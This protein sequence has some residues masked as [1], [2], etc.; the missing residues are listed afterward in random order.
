VTKNVSFRDN[1]VTIDVSH[2]IT[3]FLNANSIS[4]GGQKKFLAL[5][6]ERLKEDFLEE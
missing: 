4:R 6:K 2:F 1:F 5:L 3:I